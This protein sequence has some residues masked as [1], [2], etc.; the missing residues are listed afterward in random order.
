VIGF[1]GLSRIPGWQGLLQIDQV[2]ELALFRVK[3]SL[4]GAN[5][6]HI[7]EFRPLP[8]MERV[9]GRRRK[10]SMTLPA[11][12]ALQNPNGKRLRIGEVALDLHVFDLDPQVLALG[13]SN[14]KGLREF[15][16]QNGGI[17]VYREGVRVYD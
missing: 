10:Q 3:C 6:V 5:L 11:S 17:R 7:Y 15:L 8:Q 16:M 2:L 14:K 12:D 1:G 13:V 9:K 4:D